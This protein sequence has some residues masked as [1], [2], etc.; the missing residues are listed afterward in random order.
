LVIPLVAPLKCCCC[1]RP[2]VRSGWCSMATS[3]P[4]AYAHHMPLQLLVA[5]PPAPTMRQ[6]RVQLSSR[7]RRI[8]GSAQLIEFDRIGLSQIWPV[9]N[10]NSCPSISCSASAQPIH[11]DCS[12]RFRVRRLPPPKC[13]HDRS[14]TVSLDRLAVGPHRHHSLLKDKASTT[15]VAIHASRPSDHAN[16]QVP[17]VRLARHGH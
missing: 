17:Y 3:L 16:A 10:N 11:R 6:S 1:T 14:G 5:L 13:T 12:L 7:T 2:S 8:S 9:T 15:H 4:V